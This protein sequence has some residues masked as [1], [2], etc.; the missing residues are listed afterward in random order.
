MA[1]RAVKRTPIPLL[2]SKVNPLIGFL[3]VIMASGIDSGR[4]LT[5]TAKESRKI[6]AIVQLISYKRH[7][8]SVCSVLL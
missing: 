5:T 8:P 1:R 2:E 7:A 3:G 4:V 6:A